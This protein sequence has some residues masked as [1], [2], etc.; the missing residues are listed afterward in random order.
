MNDT[1]QLVFSYLK[2]MKV[3]TNTLFL[4][5]PEFQE[6]KQTLVSCGHQSG[7]MYHMTE[8]QEESKRS[9]FQKYPLL[10]FRNVADL[11]VHYTVLSLDIPLELMLV[12]F[13]FRLVQL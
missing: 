13:H 11:H 3:Y 6:V 10:L 4:C 8:K 2:N 1:E 7:G 5:C 9:L 12:A